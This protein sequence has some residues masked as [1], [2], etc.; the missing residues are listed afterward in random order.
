MRASWDALIRGTKVEARETRRK[1]LPSQSGK[2]ADDCVQRESPG[3]FA[4]DCR[5]LFD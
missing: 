4:R 5:G 1:K 3:I 2:A